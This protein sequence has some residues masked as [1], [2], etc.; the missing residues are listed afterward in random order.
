MRAASVVRSVGAVGL[1]AVLV[2]AGPLPVQG[3]DLDLEAGMGVSF[4]TGGMNQAW[5]P[6]P[7]FGL[8][9]VYPLS[10]RVAV[11]L[12]GDL[13]MNP[14]SGAVPDRNT[15]RYTGGVELGFTN[16]REAPGW[17]TSLGLGLGA[18]RI[19][20]DS[21]QRPGGGTS[22]GFIMTNPTFYGAV[23]LGYQA[24]RAFSFSIRWRPT[25]TLMDPDEMQ[26]FATLS[27]TDSR[28]FNEVWTMPFQVRVEVDPERL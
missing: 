21:Y 13:E 14:G 1:A 27:G 19:S 11:R 3:Q 6:A 7:I 12:D 18:M 8:G 2:A 28:W 5:N 15:I 16:P 4:P 22:S 17:T 10:E 20:T 24:T 26:D 9:A 23:R 25:L